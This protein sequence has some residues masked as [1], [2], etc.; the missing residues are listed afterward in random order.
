M[1]DIDLKIEVNGKN[2]QIIKDAK[3][4]AFYIAGWGVV[5]AYIS[6]ENGVEELTL[7][8]KNEAV[9]RMNEVGEFVLLT[10]NGSRLLEGRVPPELFP[11]FKDVANTF[12][13]LAEKEV[14]E[15]LSRINIRVENCRRW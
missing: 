10:K 11:R 13:E 9:L 14:K 6:T 5:D 4:L 8:F 1:E 2:I 15:F 12:L 7:R 3:E